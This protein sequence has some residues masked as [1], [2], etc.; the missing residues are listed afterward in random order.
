MKYGG[1][2]TPPPPGSTP[3][4]PIQRGILY[5][6]ESAERA[7]STGRQTYRICADDQC[8]FVIEFWCQK[9]ADKW[10]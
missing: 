2:Q 1:P 6:V 8:K 4:T 5:V 9:L 10:K 7:H 3:R